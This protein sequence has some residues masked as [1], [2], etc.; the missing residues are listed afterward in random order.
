MTK[1]GF[2]S[3]K[4][5]SPFHQFYNYMWM[6]LSRYRYSTKF[7]FF[8][9]YFLT[10]SFLTDYRDTTVLF[11]ETIAIKNGTLNK[12]IIMYRFSNRKRFVYNIVEINRGKQIPSFRWQI[13]S[14]KTNRIRYFF[15][16]CCVYIRNGVSYIPFH[17]FLFPNFKM[18]M[19][20]FQ[21][22][23]PDN[24]IPL[25]FSCERMELF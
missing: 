22:Q 13:F 9:I 25:E 8:L 11:P 6:R 12:K 24:R 23:G 20:F 2:I 17:F 5:D 1:R 7:C 10:I 16:V 14:H 15:I 18:E 19:C 21:W 3:F 4:Y